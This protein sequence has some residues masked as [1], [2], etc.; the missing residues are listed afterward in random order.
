[1]RLFLKCTFLHFIYRITNIQIIWG[2]SN[3]N[4]KHIIFKTHFEAWCP[5]DVL[6]Q[7]LP[8]YPAT[9]GVSCMR[10]HTE[11]FK[12]YQVEEDNLKGVS[13]PGFSLI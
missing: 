12:G 2:F 13:G 6:G 4:Q 11:I 7:Q 3:A 9:I 8:E 1:M 5:P 10:C